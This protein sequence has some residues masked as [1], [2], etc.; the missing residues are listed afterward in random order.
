MGSQAMILRAHI[1]TGLPALI[2]IGS[3]IP[4][5]IFAQEELGSARF[6]VASIKPT[7]RSHGELNLILVPRNDN[8]ITIKGTTVKQMIQFAYAP[9]PRSLSAGLVSGGPGWC[10]RDEYD[11]SAK[12]EEHRILSPKER[13]QMLKVLLEERFQLKTHR[14]SRISAVFA[15]VVDKNGPRIKRSQPDEAG[16]PGLSYCGPGCQSG[17]KVTMEM[18]A[19]FLQTILEI[20]PGRTPEFADSL[21]VIDRTGLTG[22]FVIDLHWEPGLAASGVQTGRGA[23][24]APDIFTAIQEQLGLKLHREKGLVET[25]VID[26]VQSPSPN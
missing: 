14:E 26:Q 6:D 1:S 5:S 2:L 21:P 4:A 7:D 16:P 15:L 17:R 18:L 3:L 13:K 20:F 10:D 23:V 19:D 8:I 24:N 11:I 9:G 25:V 22:P 12:S